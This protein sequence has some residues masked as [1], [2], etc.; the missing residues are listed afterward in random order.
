MNIKKYWFVILI[1]ILL[2]YLLYN[3]NFFTFIGLTPTFT[4]IYFDNSGRV[5][6]ANPYGFGVDVERMDINEHFRHFYINIVGFANNG[7][8][9]PDIDYVSVE[10]N[11]VVLTRDGY[12]WRT[13]DLSRIFND[14]CQGKRLD[15]CVV[16]FSVHNANTGD[17]VRYSARVDLSIDYNLSTE[18]VP[19]ENPP[20]PVENISIPN[21]NQ[22]DDVKT[23]DVVI[24]NHP[25][26][27]FVSNDAI[28]EHKSFL[29]NIWDYFVGLF[30][31]LT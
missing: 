13:E 23:G 16:S 9:N 24:V 20:I 6:H 1:G 28:I 14:K 19:I 7:R 5:N 26:N 29:G 27:D 22:P 30:R 3:N 21:M 15:H 12:N 18:S 2:F 31:K 10:G 17:D 8:E 25:N 11:N 4:S